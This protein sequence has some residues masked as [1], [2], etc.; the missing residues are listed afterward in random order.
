MTPSDAPTTAATRNETVFSTPSDCE[1][2]T[3]RTFD[4]PRSLV[5]AAFTD[6]VRTQKSK[7]SFNAR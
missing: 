3:T 7:L 4:A 5:W 1:L 2:V 6:P